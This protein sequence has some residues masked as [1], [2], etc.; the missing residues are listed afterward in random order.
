MMIDRALTA[1]ALCAALMFTSAPALAAGEI[2]LT[3]AKALAGNVTPGDAP[4]FPITL[5]RA[6]SYQFASVIHP[7]AGS[8]G[9]QVT[10]QDV[11]IDMSGFRLHGSG[12][13]FHGITGGVKNVTIRD[14]TI[15]GFKFDGIVGTGH[16]WLI[17]RMRVESNGR[18]G[19]VCDD[20]CLVEDAIVVSNRIGIKIST[21]I[22][23]GSVIGNNASFG[24]QGSYAGFGNSM[25]LGNNGASDDTNDGVDPLHP[26]LC[27]D[28]P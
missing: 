3:H 11:T 7:G 10:S 17:E 26:N 22:V 18:N 1:G 24:I 21:G 8:I 6:G 27:G 28:C 23:L 15:T 19:I 14:G 13:A 4:G 16:N 9:I 20:F 2:L 25:L 5:S 12:T